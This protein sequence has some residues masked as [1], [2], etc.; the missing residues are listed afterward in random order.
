MDDSEVM[1]CAATLV[2][3]KGW[4]SAA[5]AAEVHKNFMIQPE[6]MTADSIQ[7]HVMQF[8]AAQPWKQGHALKV[9]AVGEH[10]LFR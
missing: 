2:K 9:D 4:R 8:R 3:E 6:S 7:K 5:A 1:V 10:H